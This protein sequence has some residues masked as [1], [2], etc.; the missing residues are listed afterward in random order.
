[1]VRPQ[2][3]VGL[4]VGTAR[5]L[6]YFRDGP[7]PQLPLL[8]GQVEEELFLAVLQAFIDVA[9]HVVQDGQLVEL[10]PLID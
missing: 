7:L 9:R 3:L 8:V 1:M 6:A 4:L 2:E 5:F 10:T